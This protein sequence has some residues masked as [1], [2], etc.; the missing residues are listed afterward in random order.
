LL[1]DEIVPAIRESAHLFC[2]QSKAWHE[3][4]TAIDSVADQ[5]EYSLNPANDWT[6]DIIRI[7]RIGIRTEDEIT[8]DADADGTEIHPS[9]YKYLPASESVKFGTAPATE[10]VTDALLVK[11][12]FVPRLMCDEIAEWFLNF[13]QDG[14]VAGAVSDLCSRP[15][16]ATWNEATA[17]KNGRTFRNE[18][19]RAT[20][21]AE[22]NWTNQ[23]HQISGGY[24]LL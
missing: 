24:N 9:R 5:L 16:S 13:Y 6:A 12:V 15:D 14:I 7:Q 3:N 2:D 22:T 1:A 4:L 17:G 10:A 11:V 21:D 23:V 18:V 20:L 19:S 8:A